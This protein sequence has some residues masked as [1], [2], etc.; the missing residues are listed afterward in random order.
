MTDPSPSVF[1]ALADGTR[2]SVLVALASHGGA[3]ATQLAGSFPV[4]R[5]AVAKHLQVLLDAGLVAA[6]RRGRETVF[7]YV[8]GSLRTLS[9]WV[10]AVDP[11]EAQAWNE[12]V[13]ALH[14]H[15]RE[16][17]ARRGLAPSPGPLGAAASARPPRPPRA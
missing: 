14:R 10:E 2:R 13:D 12:S 7:A 1:E 3:T 5:Q 8:P 9:E 15:L 17:Q 16:Q 4:T 11:P 6:E